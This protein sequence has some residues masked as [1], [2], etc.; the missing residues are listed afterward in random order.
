[1]SKLKDALIAG[2]LK[3]LARVARLVKNNDR[4]LAYL[5]KLAEMGLVTEKEWWAM[6]V[7]YA[8]QGRW[9][10]AEEALA[11][12]LDTS[13]QNPA[14]L[15]LQ[16]RINENMGEDTKAEVLYQEVL[17]N[18]GDHFAAQFAIG[19]LRLKRGDPR[20]ALTC[21]ENCLQIKPH[22]PETLNNLGVCWMELNEYLK[23]ERCLS[24]AVELKPKNTAYAYN[25]GTLCIKLKRYQDALAAFKGINKDATNSRIL[26]SRAY[27]YSMLQEY[28]KSIELYLQAQDLEPENREIKLN[29][30]AVYAKT[31]NNELALQM[32]KELIVQNPLDPQLLNNLAWVY[33]SMRDLNAAENQYF[34]SLALS[35][36]D[37]QIAYNLFCCL[38]EKGQYIEA[39][40][41]LEY[42]KKEPDWNGISW[43][44]FAQIYETLGA[45][46]LAVDCYN[47]AFGFV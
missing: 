23:A 45:D 41:V 32:L 25:Y 14:Y 1:M 17:K 9:H 33:E 6:A 13:P 12:A 5:E 3:N 40:D 37:P 36:G 29:L 28:D 8:R 22:D 2:W 44:S 39:M 38:K 42:L 21:F 7:L 34:R 27:C 16:A 35:A 30:A 24:K 19:Q 11:F 4:S 47:R 31:G 46:K 15:F 20:G 10:K 43:S 18:K 26:S